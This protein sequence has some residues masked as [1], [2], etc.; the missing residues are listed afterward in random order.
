MATPLPGLPMST[1]RPSASSDIARL[2]SADPFERMIAAMD[3]EIGIRTRRLTR[4]ETSIELEFLRSFK[5]DLEEALRDARAADVIGNVAAAARLTRRPVSTVRRLCAKHRASAG[6]S[7]VEG[8][9]S[10][11]LPTFVAFMA[12]LQRQRPDSTSSGAPDE[13]TPSA[14][15]NT[16]APSRARMEEA[17]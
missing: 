10:I 1:F 13:R 8:E 3:A 16:L 17:A 5:S 12:T 11:H 7:Y 14:H 9:W 2:V 15:A 4:P 6:A